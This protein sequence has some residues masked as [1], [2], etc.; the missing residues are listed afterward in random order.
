MYQSLLT[1]ICQA[2]TVCTHFII[3]S[4]PSHGCTLQLSFSVAANSPTCGSHHSLEEEISFDL[5]QHFSKSCQCHYILE[6]QPRRQ[7]V[8]HVLCCFSSRLPSLP[9]PLWEQATFSGTVSMETCNYPRHQ[10]FM[11]NN[12][13]IDWMGAMAAHSS[14]TSLCH[15]PYLVLC[16]T[17]FSKMHVC[18]SKFSIQAANC[19]C[20]RV[21]CQTQTYQW[22]V[23]LK[24]SSLCCSDLKTQ[25]YDLWFDCLFAY[26]RANGDDI[27][28]WTSQRICLPW[29]FKRKRKK[30]MLIRI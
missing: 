3:S 7:R 12:F 4:V 10:Q 21:K 2:N 22:R 19:W 30:N 18:G 23:P 29:V 6:Q 20:T 8:S 14:F 13:I 11:L 17:C 1:L 16:S 9:S 5:Q 15:P 25:W 27:F 26:D 28:E 24:I